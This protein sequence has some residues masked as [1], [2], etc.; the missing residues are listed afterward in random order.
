MYK[1][2]AENPDAGAWQRLRYVTF[3]LVRPGLRAGSLLVFAFIFGAYEVP[4]IPGCVFRTWW[5]HLPLIFS[6]TPIC[7]NGRKEWQ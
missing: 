6:S 3:A 2:I 1:V 5:R 7:N 4:A